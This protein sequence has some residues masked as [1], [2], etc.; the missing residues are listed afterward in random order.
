M[1]VCDSLFDGSADK[2]FREQEYRECVREYKSQKHFDKGESNKNRKF[3]YKKFHEE[4]MNICPNNDE[5]LNIILDITYGYNGNKQFC[6][7]TI[8]DL[9]C[10]RLEEMNTVHTE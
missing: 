8:G 2:N 1:K 10:K 3:L 5:R 6:W 7:D 9:I 4:A